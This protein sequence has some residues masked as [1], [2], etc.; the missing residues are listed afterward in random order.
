MTRIFPL[1]S[2]I[3][4]GLAV[5]S[6]VVL[7]GCGAKRET[8]SVSGKVTFRGEP[9]ANATV[10]FLA[11]DGTVGSAMTKE[12]GEYN[13][14]EV[15]VG[16]VQI[17]VHSYPPSPMVVPPTGPKGDVKAQPPKFKFVRIPDRYGQPAQSGLT[18]TVTRGQQTYDI[19]LKP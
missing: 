10:T 14:G 11:K 5:V 18:H 12:G 4:F 6:I 1:G 8:G 15:A 13:V 19:A 17:T 16:P 9:L 7:S 2:G 3:V